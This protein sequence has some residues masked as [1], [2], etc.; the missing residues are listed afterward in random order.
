MIL[1]KYGGHA[2][3]DGEGVDPTLKVLAKLIKSGEQIVIV[4][5]G[6]PAINRELEVH[7]VKSEII[8][9]LRKTTP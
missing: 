9:G 6:G 2:I 5:G 1:F 7:G 3:S 8:G 4:H